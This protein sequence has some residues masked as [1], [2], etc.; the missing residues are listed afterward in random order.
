MRN[1]SVNVCARIVHDD[2]VRRKQLKMGV[3]GMLPWRQLP[4]EE[5]NE[6][7]EVCRLHLQVLGD[8]KLLEGVQVIDEYMGMELEGWTDPEPYVA[9]KN[10]ADDSAPED[11]PLP[12]DDVPGPRVTRRSRN[13]RN[14]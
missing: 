13:P 1:V 9:S 3:E 2:Y 8:M 11:T 4:P 7:A 5:R 14:E 10:D 12:A 6:E